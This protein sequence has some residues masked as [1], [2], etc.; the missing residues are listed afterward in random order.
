MAV[1][2]PDLTLRIGGPIFFF[3]SAFYAGLAFVSRSFGLS[4]SSAL[5]DHNLRPLF[6]FP[7]FAALTVGMGEAAVLA[8]WYESA[9]WR[10][11]NI[12]LAISSMW[13]IAFALTWVYLR[14]LASPVAL[15]Y[16]DNA[17]CW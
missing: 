4:A 9:T 6:R 13:L 15:A 12:V 1:S 16:L 10:D 5:Q 2:I 11:P 7:N 3:Y 17:T 14:R 8:A